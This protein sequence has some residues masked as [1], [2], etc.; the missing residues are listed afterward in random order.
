M[1]NFNSDT[2][3]RSNRRWRRRGEGEGGTGSCVF[4]RWAGERA[5]KRAGLGR[6]AGRG[7]GGRQTGGREE[8]AGERESGPERG[9]G[10]VSAGL[11][12]EEGARVRPGRREK[13]AR[14]G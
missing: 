12:G 10:L 7:L 6:S 14:F 2:T 5:S 4:E 8:Q 11:G 9:D 3:T 13:M 1:A